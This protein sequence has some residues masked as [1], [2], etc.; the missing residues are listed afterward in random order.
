MGNNFYIA[1]KNIADK[2]MTLNETKNIKKVKN[3]KIELEK[4]E[5][6]QDIILSEEQKE[7]IKAVND[8]NVCI[9]TGGPRNW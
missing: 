2:L 5:K 7:A 9:I 3:F 4:A 6:K 8:N 1:E